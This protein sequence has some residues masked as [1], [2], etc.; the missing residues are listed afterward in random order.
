MDDDRT[1]PCDG[2]NGQ[3]GSLGE[4]HIT[5]PG[6]SLCERPGRV[7]DRARRR[8]RC[9][10]RLSMV[11]VPS[12]VVHPVLPPWLAA[13]LAGGVRSSQRPPRYLGI[14]AIMRA[15]T[16]EP[17][18]IRTQD[19]RIKSLSRPPSMGS[20]WGTLRR[21]LSRPSSTCS[22]R[23]TECDR[24][25]WQ[26]GWQAATDAAGSRAVHGSRAR[27]RSRNAI[28]MPPAIIAMPTTSRARR[29]ARPVHG[30]GSVG[31]PPV[32]SGRLA[33]RGCRGER[34]RT[35]DTATT[36]ARGDGDPGGVTP[37]VRTPRVTP[38]APASHRGP[39][40]TASQGH[41]P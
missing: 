12:H 13:W 41:R 37:V 2:R 38:E 18:G 8:L 19:T 24:R 15:N 3:L 29:A 14:D 21:S 11:S 9:G 10:R 25:G 23:G 30:I 6:T 33:R 5:A 26:R 35:G 31:G 28:Q 4:R 16:G 22:T 34:A 39:S 17:A 27:L 36:V 7:R 40:G 32:G 1:D 20:L